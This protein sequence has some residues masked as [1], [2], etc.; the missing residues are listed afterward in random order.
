MS[1]EQPMSEI[2]QIE[3]MAAN[4]FTI[5]QMA[6]QLGFDFAAFKELAETEDSDY[7]LAIRRG[8]LRTEF[9]ITDK[10]RQLAESGN[11]TATQIFQKIKDEKRIETIKNRIWFGE[12]N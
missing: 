7:W 8:R 2:D 4:D 11:I 9:N 12:E 5:R 3:L 1:E 6:L 10:Q